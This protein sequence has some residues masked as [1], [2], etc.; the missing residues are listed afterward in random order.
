M[1]RR[2][3]DF[4][5]L[6]SLLNEPPSEW[7]WQQLCALVFPWELEACAEQWL[8]YAEDMLDRGWPDA[9]RVWPQRWM[10]NRQP[11]AA[12]L[13]RAVQLTDPSRGLLT[14]LH[15]A[16]ALHRPPISALAFEPRRNGDELKVLSGLLEA[17]PTLD[18]LELHLMSLWEPERWRG[19]VDA[20]VMGQ[21]E[22]LELLGCQLPIEG[23]RALLARCG[24]LR[25]LRLVSNH[26]VWG[27]ALVE[28]LATHDAPRRLEQ[29][30]VNE[31]ESAQLVALSALPWERLERLELLGSIY[32]E[33][34]AQVLAAP[35]LGRVQTLRVDC[36]SLWTGVGLGEAFEGADEG[37]RVRELR[38]GSGADDAQ[39]AR[40]LRSPALS[41]LERLWMSHA[42]GAATL[43]ALT[44][45][46][47]ER[48]RGL[49]IADSYHPL[50]EP[51]RGEQMELFLSARW[52]ALE[53]LEVRNAGLNDAA[54][55]LLARAELP[56]LRALHIDQDR[57]ASLPEG[58]QPL[59]QGI[60]PLAESSW[61]PRL[62]TLGRSDDLNNRGVLGRLTHHPRAD[63][64]LRRHV[65]R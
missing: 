51:L 2:T 8:P 24:R 40:A 16:L 45:V 50:G 31:M 55:G 23:L 5:E 52:S 25:A 13:V 62:Q 38:L 59:D 32:D 35:G 56:A 1:T 61:F 18:A 20:P 54:L 57:R 26:Y 34:L 28:G 65:A 36:I 48:L 29:L 14:Q 19:L 11:S 47:G 27:A 30:A 22:R 44:S 42:P 46:H 64:R 4:G 60:A 10:A 49:H 17:M 21:L 7:A 6:R 63:R 9:L 39:L 15:A 33:T 3:I 12:Q 37:L 53:V 41:Q 58:E 43:E